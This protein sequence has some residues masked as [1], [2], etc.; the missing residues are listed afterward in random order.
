MIQ[1]NTQTIENN[2]LIS[3]WAILG[4]GGILLQAIIKLY[5]LAV[6][7]IVQQ[8]LS[9]IQ[10]LFFGLWSI[11][12]VYTEGYRGFQKAFSPRVV[13][14]AWTLHRKSPRLHIIVAPLY[15]MGYF[16]ASR[17]RKLVSWILTAG[18]VGVVLIV[19][20]LPYPYRN[21]VDAGVVL[22]LSYGLVT[23]LVISV[24]AFLGSLPDVNPDLPE[25]NA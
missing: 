21:I 17:K 13:R 19:K 18:I 12:M 2:T 9:I 5:P 16:Y 22:G 8:D 4:V 23:L 11:F 1:R 10:W 7:P 24:Q 15:S 20:V 3:L 6:Q 25:E 14:R